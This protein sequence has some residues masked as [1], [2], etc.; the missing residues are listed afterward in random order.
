MRWKV[1]PDPKPHDYRVVKR[2]AFLP[3]EVD[4]EA[5]WW[6]T[7]YILQQYSKTII[8][9][10]NWFDR[11]FTTEEEYRKYLR[12]NKKYKPSFKLR[13]LRQYTSTIEKELEERIDNE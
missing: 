9:T 8:N 3:I 13:H 7:V 10:Y 2:F 1:E 4:D 5:R 11:N 12:Y 6:E